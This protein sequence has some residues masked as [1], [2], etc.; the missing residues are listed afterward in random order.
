MVV[1][2]ITTQFVTR[3]FLH[4]SNGVGEEANLIQDG[5]I[6]FEL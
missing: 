6:S 3:Y 2:H 5:K 1:V 4:C